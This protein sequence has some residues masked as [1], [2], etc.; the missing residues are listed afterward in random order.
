MNVERRT[1]LKILT[2]S[3]AVPTEALRAAAT[4]CSASGVGSTFESYQFVFFT[5]EEQALVDRLMELIIPADAHSPGASAARVPAFADMMISTGSDTTKAAW[6]AGLAQFRDASAGGHLE[7][8]LAQAAAEE[9][10]P[11]SAAGRFFI[12]LKRM[13]VDGYYTSTIG[14]QKE[15]RYEGNTH[16]TSAPACKHPEHGAA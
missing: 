1:L 13:T 14:I 10:A 15:L 12:D 2:A 16:M 5:P 11:K 6:R 9:N 7:T 8:V 4:Q 3:A